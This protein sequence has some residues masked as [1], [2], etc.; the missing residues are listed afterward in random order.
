MAAFLCLP[1]GGGLSC[2]V[3]KLA[4]EFATGVGRGDEQ[5]LGRGGGGGVTAPL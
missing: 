4:A 1:S 3:M 2:W 5:V